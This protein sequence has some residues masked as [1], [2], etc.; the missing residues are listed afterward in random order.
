MGAGRSIRTLA[1]MYQTRSKHDAA[2]VPTR[3]LTTLF[4]WSTSFNWQERVAERQREEQ[5]AARQAARKEA[6]VLARRRL[7]RAQLMQDAGAAML[8]KAEITKLEPEDARALLGTA[9]RYMVEGMKAERLEL[10]EMAEN[11][12]P[13]KDISMMSDEELADFLYVM[14]SQQ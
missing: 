12:R 2:S 14:E 3:H 1:D 10:G 9:L 4:N 13:P 6:K 11:I 8:N 7:N 5:Y